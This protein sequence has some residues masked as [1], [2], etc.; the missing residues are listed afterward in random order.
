MPPVAVSAN[1]HD[2]F[3]SLGHS[4]TPHHI[5]PLQIH[6][7]DGR[8]CPVAVCDQ[9][10]RVI[11]GS[12]AGNAL[13]VA[14]ESGALPVQQQIFFTHKQCNR[15]FEHTKL[16]ERERQRLLSDELDVFLYRLVCNSGVDLKDAKHNAQLLELA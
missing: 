4:T 6:T 3:W 12:R 14:P 15:E 11:T 13:W 10:G 8:S 7:K 1:T 5:M 16:S 9:C 2:I